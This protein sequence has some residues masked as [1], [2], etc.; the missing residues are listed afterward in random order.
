[1]PIFADIAPQALAWIAA[2]A[3]VAGLVRGFSGFGTAMI[4]LP[5]AGQF[6]SPGAALTA[7]V[8]MDIVAP[9]AMVPRAL[10]D[11]DP[12]DVLRLALGLAL[13]M[14]LGVWVL[15]LVPAEVFRY[16][17][18]A[19]TLGLLVLLIAGFRYQG[20]LT[21]PMVTGTG[22]LG[23]LLGGS[24][25]LPGPPVIMLYMASP[26][27]ASAIR[28][29]ITLYLILADIALITLLWLFGELVWNALALGAAL[30]IPYP[31]GIMVGGRLFVPEY[32]ALYR[33]VA[34]V[35]IAVSALSGLP[36][37]D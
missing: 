14:P 33:A 24:V 35:I 15:T 28:A 16:A 25:G 17:V 9:M 2:A 34:Y 12:P 32:E 37:W 26:H 36:V 5:V 1:M 10:R 6:L 4:Y 21:P 27:P 18:S 22:A 8:I 30:L 11:G 20:R 13:A 23:G 31:I 7:L 3:L 19:L 29:N